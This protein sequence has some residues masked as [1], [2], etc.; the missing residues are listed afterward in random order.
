MSQDGFVNTTEKLVPVWPFLTMRNLDVYGPLPSLAHL[1]AEQAN[2]DANP[3]LIWRFAAN[4]RRRRIILFD[5]EHYISDPSLILEPP[6]LLSLL[7]LPFLVWQLRVSLGAQFALSTS[8]A[9]LFIMFNPVVTPII[10][11]LTVPWLL[12]RFVWL[13]PYA[14]TFA[15][16]SQHLLDVSIKVLTRLLNLQS[17]QSALLAGAPLGFVIMFGFLLRPSIIA[18]I[19][20]IHMRSVGP[21]TYPTPEKI[22][23]RLKEETS[24]S[25]PA[26]VLADEEL[27]SRSKITSYFGIIPSH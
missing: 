27:S 11:M 7:L 8:L 15:L 16:V 12:W 17:A 3:F 14:L 9:V 6:Y 5:L 10:G 20:E 2:T 25:G 22:M 26:I 13:L 4:M 19:E 1:N 23:T 21:I 18:N 24:I